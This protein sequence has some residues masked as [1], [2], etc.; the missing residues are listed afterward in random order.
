[1]PKELVH[2]GGLGM[3]LGVGCMLGLVL[4]PVHG[5]V[6]GIL[7]GPVL[8]GWGGWRLG[9]EGLGVRSWVSGPGVLWSC[10]LWPWVLVFGP[11]FLGAGVLGSRVLGK[12]AKKCPI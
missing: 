4:V 5:P 7:L 11:W 3:G 10:G 8:R 2:V 6:L 12:S 1:M 9:V